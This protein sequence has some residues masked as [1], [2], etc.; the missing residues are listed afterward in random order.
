LS[1]QPKRY[2]ALDDQAG[3]VGAALMAM[4]NALDPVNIDRMLE[5]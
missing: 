4:E 3:M 2:V 1:T 5:L